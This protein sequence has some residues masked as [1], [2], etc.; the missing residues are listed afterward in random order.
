MTTKK[1]IKRDACMKFYD[2]SRPL[3]LE[4]DASGFGLGTRLLQMKDSMNG[5]H[6]EVPHNVTL[7]PIAFAIKSLMSAEQYYRNIE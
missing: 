6:D 4:T 5:G 7:C 1:I 2:T 3:Y